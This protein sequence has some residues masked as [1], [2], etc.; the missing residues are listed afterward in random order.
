MLPLMPFQYSSHLIPIFPTPQPSPS[1]PLVPLP[2]I[3]APRPALMRSI[4][5]PG[6]ATATSHPALRPLREEGVEGKAGGERGKELC[7]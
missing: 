5:R 1:S 2:P 6:V 3:A 7:G 4:N